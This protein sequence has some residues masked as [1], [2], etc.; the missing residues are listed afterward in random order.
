MLTSEELRQVL[1]A[2]AEGVIALDRLEALF[3]GGGST[4]EAVLSEMLAESEHA[5]QAVSL[6]R[7][8][9]D[10][11]RDH[12]EEEG[13]LTRIPYFLF[14]CRTSDPGDSGH[15]GLAQSELVRAAKTE[16]GS[17]FARLTPR[18][19]DTSSPAQLQHVLGK[20]LATGDRR[21][22]CDAGQASSHPST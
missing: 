9:Y 14:C 4:D 19:L 2:H 12:Q 20:A 10:A 8:V 22:S 16:N 18:T 21:E 1:I 11:V 15:R 7:L 3:Y 6:A 17:L 13:A 5:V